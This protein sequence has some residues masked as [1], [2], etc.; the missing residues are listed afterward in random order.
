MLHDFVVELDATFDVHDLMSIYCHKSKNKVP[1]MNSTRFLGKQE[2]IRLELS[3]ALR[4][5]ATVHGR[6]PS[7]K[8][9]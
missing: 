4:R 5:K 8:G 6:K 3:T 7:L 9:N 1:R 2:T